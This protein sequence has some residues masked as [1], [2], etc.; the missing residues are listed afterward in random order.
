MGRTWVWGLSHNFTVVLLIGALLLVGGTTGAL[1]APQVIYL[2]KFPTHHGQ[3]L[4]GDSGPQTRP[5]EAN[6]SQDT[7]PLLFNNWTGGLQQGTS[8]QYAATESSLQECPP[9][10]RQEAYSSLCHGA[11]VAKPSSTSL[12]HYVR[13]MVKEEGGLL[14]ELRQQSRLLPSDSGRG[15]LPRAPC[16]AVAINF[17]MGTD[18]Q[19]DTL[20]KEAA[21]ATVAAPTA[22]SEGQG[23]GRPQRQGKPDQRGGGWASAPPQVL[24]STASGSSGDDSQLFDFSNDYRRTASFGR[25]TTS[26]QPTGQLENCQR[27]APAGH[28]QALGRSRCSGDASACQSAPQSCFHATQRQKGIEQGSPRKTKLLVLLGVLYR[29]AGGIATEAVCGTAG[30]VGTVYGCRVQ[31]DG[32]APGEHYRACQTLSW[33]PNCSF[34]L[35]RDGPL[36]VPKRPTVS[37]RSFGAYL[38]ADGRHASTWTPRRVQN[39]SPRSQGRRGKDGQG[40]GKYRSCNGHGGQTYAAPQLGSDRRL[41]RRPG[42]FQHFGVEQWTHSVT[43]VG[44]FVGPV[45]AQTMGLVLDFHC[46]LVANG[47]PAVSHW[48][49]SRIMEDVADVNMECAA[50]AFLE[51]VSA[52]ACHDRPPSCHGQSRLGRVRMAG[53]VG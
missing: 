15:L 14:R 23:Q 29:Q 6:Q 48:Q 13:P 31:M 8:R 1:F 9:G 40:Q 28:S 22:P 35:G 11:D 37:T 38:A 3:R 53:G 43:E 7:P 36:R 4:R 33:K 19:M 16:A 34:R 51:G 42:P 30:H 44:D 39:S 32:A 17:V 49:D 50:T 5:Q 26:G 10:T 41:Q 18:A 2:Y 46:S 45:E 12:V 47:L 20:S 27:D 21:E 24:A 52:A 25:P